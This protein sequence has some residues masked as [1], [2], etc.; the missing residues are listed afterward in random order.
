MVFLGTGNED[1]SCHS[2]N[3]LSRIRPL[4]ADRRNAPWNAR[5]PKIARQKFPLVGCQTKPW[6]ESLNVTVYIVPILVEKIPLVNSDMFAVAAITC[7][8]AGSRPV[9]FSNSSQ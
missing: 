5:E 6:R 1:C 4:L 7:V 2:A 9:H 8:R 3:P